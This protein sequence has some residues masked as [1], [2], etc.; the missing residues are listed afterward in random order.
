MYSEVIFLLLYLHLASRD[1]SATF[2]DHAQ[3]ICRSNKGKEP[4]P[5]PS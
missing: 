3:G 2:L 5:Q 1:E 4:Q